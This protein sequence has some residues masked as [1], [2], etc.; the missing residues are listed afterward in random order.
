MRLWIAARPLEQ[1]MGNLAQKLT[2]KVTPVLK[3]CVLEDMNNDQKS[4]NFCWDEALS[5]GP[6]AVKK[7]DKSRCRVKA[8]G[9]QHQNNIP[10]ME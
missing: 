8:R 9:W 10:E 5:L 2:L 7:L 1:G 4:T 3:V 6:I